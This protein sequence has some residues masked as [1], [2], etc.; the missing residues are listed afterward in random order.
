[1]H[2]FTWKGGPSVYRYQE[3]LEAFNEKVNAFLADHEIY[4]SYVTASSD[5][6]GRTRY[7]AWF[8]YRE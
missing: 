1:M 3:Q 2:I 5:E 6:Q 7:I 4:D 8:L